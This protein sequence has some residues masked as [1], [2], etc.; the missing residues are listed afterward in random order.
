MRKTSQQFFIAL[1]NYRQEWNTLSSRFL[2]K[3]S[4][5]GYQ[6][7]FPFLSTDTDICLE[8]GFLVRPMYKHCIN[9]N[10]PTMAIIGLQICAY[11]LMYDMQ[12]QLCFRYWNNEIP[13]PSREEMLADTKLEMQKQQSKS[14][15]LRKSHLL[16]VD[17][18]FTE[19]DGSMNEI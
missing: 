7:S 13:M 18:V 3:C 11:T 14:E 1:V 12:V 8:E 5:S 15:Q 19:D 4:H 10:H 6:Y 9:I 17:Q 2:N 16:G